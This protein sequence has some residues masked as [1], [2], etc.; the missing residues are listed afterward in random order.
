MVTCDNVM[1]TWSALISFLVIA[2][3]WVIAFH[4][5]IAFDW[6]IDH[7][8]VFE[9]NTGLVSVVIG[10]VLMFLLALGSVTVFDI[11]KQ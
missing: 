5:V 4:W 3:D 2:F 6:V 7:L 1:M 9:V 11:S 10:L 8:R